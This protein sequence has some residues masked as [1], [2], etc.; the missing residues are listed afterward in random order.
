MYKNKYEEEFKNKKE[1]SRKRSNV[2]DIVED[3]LSKYDIILKLVCGL[4]E[5]IVKLKKAVSIDFEVNEEAVDRAEKVS[6]IAFALQSCIDDKE[7]G[8]LAKNL[9]WLYRFVRF[10]CKRLIDNEDL[11]YIKPAH[12]IAKDLKEGWLGM[13][14][15]QRK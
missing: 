6:K 2:N 1:L 3:K 15:E 4:E 11:T 5:E 12:I 9:H 14:S 8:D 7:G 13:P 10:S